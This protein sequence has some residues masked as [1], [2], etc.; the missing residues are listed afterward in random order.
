VAKERGE[1][2]NDAETE[3]DGTVRKLRW[4]GAAEQAVRGRCLLLAGL[5]LHAGLPLWGERWPAC[6]QATPIRLALQGAVG[7]GLVGWSY[8]P[9]PP[10]LPSL[11]G[12]VPVTRRMSAPSTA[13]VSEKEISNGSGRFSPRYTGFQMCR[14]SLTDV[15]Q[16]VPG[17]APLPMPKLRPGDA[18][19][20]RRWHAIRPIPH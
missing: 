4:I 7:S 11:V 17:G 13:F 14:Q 3:A 18:L 10:L 8:R 19:L 20:T 2:A 1:G 5:A 12:W 16:G 15:G 9:P 6:F